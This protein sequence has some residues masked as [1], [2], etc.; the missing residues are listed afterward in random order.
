MG[1]ARPD[2][3]GTVLANRSGN[4]RWAGVGIA[5]ISDKVARVP[6]ARAVLVRELPVPRRHA[7]RSYTEG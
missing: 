4:E 2:P 3:A 5:H 7:A 6:T 1:D